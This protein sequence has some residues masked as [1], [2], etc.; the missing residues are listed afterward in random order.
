MLAQIF[1]AGFR[2]GEISCPTKYFPEASSISF[3]NSVRYGLG[4]LETMFRFR[5]H[6]MKLFKDPI[7]N[8]IEKQPAKTALPKG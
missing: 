3:K 4:V 7:F 1:Y 6:C 8:G 5:L 2:V